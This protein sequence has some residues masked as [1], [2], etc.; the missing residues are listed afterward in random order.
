M[1]RTRALARLVS[2]VF[3]AIT[4]PT[5]V[6]GE[7][8]GT[9]PPA[10]SI[11]EWKAS[12]TAAPT[13]VAGDPVGTTPP[14]TSIREWKVDP[15]AAPTAGTTVPAKSIREWR[16]NPTATPTTSPCAYAEN[17]PTASP[18]AKSAVTGT[19]PKSPI[20]ISISSSLRQGSLVILLDDVPV[21][22]EKF[23]KPVLLISQTTTWDPLQIAAGKHRLSAKVYGAKKTY[24]SKLYDLE[25]SR[26]KGNKLRFVLQGDKLT[27][28]LA[29]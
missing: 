14:A 2:P 3:V 28:E 5:L 9:T 8:V 25:V 27:V 29:S 24:F 26:T 11:R 23:Q 7:P 15:N 16:A 20:T 6:A 19:T 12:P 13:V 22:N 4:M 1:F 18:V 10:K 21:F 17:T